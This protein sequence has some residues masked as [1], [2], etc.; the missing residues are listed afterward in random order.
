MNKLKRQYEKCDA[1][2]TKK[3]LFNHIHM[4]VVKVFVKIKLNRIISH[5]QT[6]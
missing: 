3:Y 2:S 4:D 5:G 6:G 1:N